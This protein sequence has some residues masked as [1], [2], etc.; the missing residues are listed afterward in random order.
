[1]KKAAQSWL[2]QAEEDIRYAKSALK[3]SFYAWVCFAAQQSAEKSLKAVL[4]EKQ[5]TLEKSHR[6]IHLAKQAEHFIPEI[7]ELHDKLDVLNQYY[8]ATRYADLHDSAAPY[9]QYDEKLAQEA[10][11]FAEAILKVVQAELK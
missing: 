9:E 8:G 4:V 6:L 3:D 7:A 2:K 10:I 1:M 5:N 11:E